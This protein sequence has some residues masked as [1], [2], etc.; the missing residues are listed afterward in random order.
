MTV[1]SGDAVDEL[2]DLEDDKIIEKCMECMK[3]LFPGQVSKNYLSIEVLSIHIQIP[4]EL[5]SRFH[6]NQSINQSTLF[7]I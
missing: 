1:I 5:L 2:K 7:F 6:I 3:G 4:P